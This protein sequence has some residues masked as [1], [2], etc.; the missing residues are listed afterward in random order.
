M[1]AYAHQINTPYSQCQL[2]TP[3]TVVRCKSIPNYNRHS[4]SHQQP[5][6]KINI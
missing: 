1:Y 5:Y 3:P 2:N 4:P 6:I